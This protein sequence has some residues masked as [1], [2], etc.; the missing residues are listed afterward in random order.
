MP[1]YMILLTEND[2]A[3]KKLSEEQRGA[4]LKKY[5]AWVGL[6][7]EQGRMRGGE[8]L[9]AGGRVLSAGAGGVGERPYTETKDVLTGFFL[10]EAKDLDEA[11]AVARGCPALEHG[12]TVLV[13]PVADY[14]TDHAGA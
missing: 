4:L 12:E 7:K 6:L 5:F 13:R 1:Q 11:A 14:S 9:A 10:I 8:P 2:Q 3:W